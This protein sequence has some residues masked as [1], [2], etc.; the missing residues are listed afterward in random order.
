M[1]SKYLSEL[2]GSAGWV[3]ASALAGAA[4]FV[5]TQHLAGFPADI[6]QFIGREIV[7]Q[8]SYD[9][10]LAGV[11]GWA[12]H[13][14]V[15]L[16]YATLYASIVLAPAIPRERI[17]RWGAGAVIAA[18]LGWLTTLVTAPA[19]AVTIGLLSGNG[20][21][22]SLPALNTAVGFVLWN[23]LGFFLICFA[24]TVVIRDSARAWSTTPAD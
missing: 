6:A 17:P 22:A 1:A 10:G 16:A 23:H 15:A 9:P 7:R 4:A 14:A 2:V 11:I 8:G 13:L 20:L 24:I 12:V 5:T 18:A 21:P 3:L 19:I